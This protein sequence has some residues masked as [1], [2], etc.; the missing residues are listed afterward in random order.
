MREGTPQNTE[1]EPISIID[2]TKDDTLNFLR[3]S[4]VSD[5]S[6]GAFKSIL[7][8]ILA[9]G[10]WSCSCAQFKLL[11]NHTY[12]LHFTVLVCLSLPPVDRTLL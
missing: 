7:N 9:N 4:P 12:E 6:G 11:I 10:R 1:Q 3:F 8:P 5:C 2:D